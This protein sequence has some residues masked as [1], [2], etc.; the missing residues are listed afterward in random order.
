MVKAIKAVILF[1]D[2]RGST[3]FGYTQGLKMYNKMLR[4][5]H[6]TCF[7]AIERFRQD[8]SLEAARV[9]ATCRG[10]ECCVFLC[11][12]QTLEDELLAMNLAVYLKEM[13][14]QSDFCRLTRQAADTGL[15]PQV[16]LRI[17]IGSGEVALDDDVWSGTETLEGIFISEAKRIEEQ[18]D[19][20]PETLIMVKWEIQNA[21]I[22]AGAEVEFGFPI[23]LKGRGVPHSVD[24][25]VYPVKAYAEWKA[26]EKKLVPSPRTYFQRLGHA[27]ALRGSGDLE[28]A[29]REYGELLKLRPGDPDALNYRAV[30]LGQLGRH[31][32]ALADFN[33]S[34]ELR[35]DD[36]D[37]LNNRGATLGHLRRYDEALPDF[38]RSLELRPDDPDTLYNRGTTLGR[39]KRYEEALPDFNRSLELRPDHPDVLTNRGVTLRHFKRYEEAVADYNRSLELRPDHPITLSN[40]GAALGCL[41]RYEEALADCNRALQLQPGR[42]DALYNRACLSSLMGRYEEAVPDL[43]AAIAG[44]AEYGRTAREDEDLEGLRNDPKWGPK[45]WELVGTEDQP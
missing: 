3:G 25:P 33:R 14:K 7:E 29:I 10:D 39:L 35:P 40:R 17:G 27:V 8:K 42:S 15:I 30:A 32:E 24:V 36:P 22:R 31:E 26:I 28:G 6:K 34:L 37:T 45:F 11:G 13:W 4:D 5:F 23:R 9:E 12:G 1:A 16:D 43:R 20:A 38:N 18:A 19:A 2:I 44:D 41:K 21:C